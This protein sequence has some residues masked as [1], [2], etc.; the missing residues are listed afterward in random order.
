MPKYFSQKEKPLGLQPVEISGKYWAARWK[1]SIFTSTF[2]NVLQRPTAYIKYL[3]K[4]KGFFQENSL[5][6]VILTLSD[7]P[8]W[9]MSWELQIKKIRVKSTKVPVTNVKVPPDVYFSKS[10]WIFKLA[11]DNFGKNDPEFFN[12]ARDIYR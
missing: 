11:R 8:N 10:S 4:V 3:P 2:N 12:V 9:P 7:T 6:I 5:K 1:C